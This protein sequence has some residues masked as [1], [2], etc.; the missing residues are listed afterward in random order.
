MAPSSRRKTFLGRRIGKR[1]LCNLLQ[2]FTS[3]RSRERVSLTSFKKREVR[4]LESGRPFLKF[5][6]TKGT[7]RPSW[8]GPRPTF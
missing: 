6:D 1:N 8:P 3:Q 7:S 5:C 4:G 2:R